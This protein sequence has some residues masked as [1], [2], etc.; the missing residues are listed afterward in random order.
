MDDD[1]IEGESATDAEDFELVLPSGASIGHR[2]L[3]RYFKQRPNS[4]MAQK[5]ATPRPGLRSVLF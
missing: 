2:H 3:K 4:V 1:E 5:A